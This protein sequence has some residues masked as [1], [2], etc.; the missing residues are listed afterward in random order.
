M[1]NGRRNNDNDTKRRATKRKLRAVV[2]AS[3]GNERSD[4]PGGELQ[5]DE[6]TFRADAE[7]SAANP[8]RVT[9]VEGTTDERQGDVSTGDTNDTRAEQQ[10]VEGNRRRRRRRNPT[11]GKLEW[12]DYRDAADNSGNNGNENTEENSV[13]Y[14]PPP[15]RKR[16]RRRVNDDIEKAAMLGLI[17]VG[18]TSL[19]ETIALFAGKHW[20]LVEDE[21]VM[22][23]H[24][25][26]GALDTLPGEYYAVIKKLIEDYFPW[27]T[28]SIVASKIVIPRL[29]YK[30]QPQYSTTESDQNDSTQQSSSVH[31]KS[32]V[33]TGSNNGTAYRTQSSFR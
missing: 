2:S 8:F 7:R 11:T 18:C 10:T 9:N 25:I 19:F 6:R 27:L 12:G 23:A 14:E 24:A 30:P 20:S 15:I 26:D 17:A 1:R 4:Q 22:L 28:L 5:G 33:D 32:T 16:R 29:N 13:P 31:R 3:G 21:T